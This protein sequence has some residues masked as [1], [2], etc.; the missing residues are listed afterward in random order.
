MSWAV[1]G[2]FAA[3]ALFALLATVTWLEAGFEPAA[4]QPLVPLLPLVI[5]CAAFNALGEE[6]VYRS[7]PLAALVGVVGARQALLMTSVWFGLAHYFGSI[8]EGFG[9]VVQPGAL[10]LLGSAMVTTKGLGWPFLMHV[11]VDL[12][13]F[14]SIALVST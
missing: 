6:V 1:L 9:G 13:V 10:A 12:V 2:T 3:G 8:P 4:L 7:G 5:G 14:A 11:A